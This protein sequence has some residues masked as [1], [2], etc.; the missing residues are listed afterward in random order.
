METLKALNRDMQIVLGGTLLYVIISV[1]DWQSYSIG[2]Y[3]YGVTLWH[4]FGVLVAIIALALLAWELTRAFGISVPI[5]TLTPG[6][7]SAGLAALLLV[8]TVIIFL[9]WS[10]VRAWP[11]WLGLALA[12]AIGVFA[13]KRAKAEGVEMPNLPKSSGAMGGGGTPTPPEPPAGGDSSL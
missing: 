6:V 5:G 7:V 13:F 4:G 3:S 12:I 1:F 9:D 2:P 8:F 10:Q 11:E